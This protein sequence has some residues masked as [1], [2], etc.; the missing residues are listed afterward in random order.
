MGHEIMERGVD[1][2]TVVNGHTLVKD[3]VIV[4]TGASDG[5]GA[6]AARLLN[7]KGAHVII[8]GRLPKKSKD[9]ANELNAPYY[10]ADFSRLEDVRT[11]ASRLKKDL[12]QIDV[13]ANNAGG[14][15]GERTLTVD[16]H[17]MTMQVNHLAPFLLTNLLLD[18]LIASRASVIATSS[19]AHRSAGKLDL[20]NIEIEHGYRRSSAYGKAKLM[21]ILFTRELHKRYNDKGISAAAFHPGSVRTSFSSEFGGG[22][23]F[24]YGSFLKRFLIDPAQGADTMVWL[25]T[26]KPGIDWT[27]GG[28]YHKRK[29][30]GTSKQAQDAKLA[31]DLWEISAKF[32]GLK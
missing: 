28:Y 4:I 21:N 31:H 22:W 3:K 7:A 23:N 15:M 12:P 11:L 6:A 20:N 10:L 9:I 24:V 32:T 19:I 25:A 13:L 26:S 1:E 2:R 30:A 27:S 5:I 8:V 17:E 16:G 14:V 18:T 29:I